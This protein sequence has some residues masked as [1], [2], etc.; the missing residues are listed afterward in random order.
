M[1][2]ESDGA[3]APRVKLQKSDNIDCCEDL[4]GKFVSRNHIFKKGTSRKLRVYAQA[5]SHE[6]SRGGESTPSIYPFAMDT[7]GSFCDTPI[8]FLKKIAMVKFSNEPGSEP[9]LAWKRVIWVQ[10][11]CLLIQAALLR[12]ASRSFHRGLCKCFEEDYEHLF[13]TPQH[14][15]IDNDVSG[16]SPIY[17]PAAG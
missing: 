15:T 11:T 16:L 12:E 5:R 7:S 8:L 10:E 14:S 6:I 13:D 17:I 3:S 1:Q 2:Q 4:K 9:L